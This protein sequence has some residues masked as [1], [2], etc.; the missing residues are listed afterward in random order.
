[1]GAERDLA[2]PVVDRDAGERPC[3]GGTDE[4]GDDRAGWIMRRDVCAGDEADNGRASAALMAH[5]CEMALRMMR[6]SQRRSRH[7]RETCHSAMATR[8]HSG[9]VACNIIYST[10]AR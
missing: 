9:M 4:A 7:G 3:Q 2:A 6:A 5:R 10:A 1:M 8:I